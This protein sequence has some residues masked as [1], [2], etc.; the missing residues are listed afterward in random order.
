MRKMCDKC[1][2]FFEVDPEYIGYNVICPNCGQET[3]VKAVAKKTPPPTQTIVQQ[4]PEVNVALCF[5]LGLSF[6]LIGLLIA[7]IIGKQKGCVAG[8]WG[9][10]TADIIG[11][12]LW[13]VFG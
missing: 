6:N 5:I 1:M 2:T 9:M 3:L 7:A 8:L 11:L 4:V 12:V 10:F 13:M